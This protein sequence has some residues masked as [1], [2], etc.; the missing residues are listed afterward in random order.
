MIA[1][2]NGVVMG[3]GVHPEPPPKGA[4]DSYEGIDLLGSYLLLFFLP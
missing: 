4:D 3:V 2:D 1:R